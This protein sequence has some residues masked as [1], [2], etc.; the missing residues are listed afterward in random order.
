MKTWLIVLISV[1]ATFLVTFSL[2]G[3]S[4]SFLSKSAGFAMESD[5]INYRSYSPS[6]D[7][8]PE[9]EE[10]KIEKTAS[11]LTKVGRGEVDAKL[12]IA[13]STIKGMGGFVLND[14]VREHDDVRS[15]TLDIR[16]PTDNYDATIAELRKL[17]DI[18][19]FTE[20]ARDIT[21]AVVN[22]DLE[23]QVQKER[24]VRLQSLYDER[25]SLEDKIRLDELI[26]QQERTIKYLEDTL[27]KLDQKVV[28]SS[29]SLS[30][31]EPD[32]VWSALTID[33]KEI[34]K[35]CFYSLKALLYTVAAL[36]PWALVIGGVVWLI[37][38]LRRAWK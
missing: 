2:F 25:A 33:F 27:E 5:S 6:Q 35:T 24:L 37:L 14:N 34:V 23:L 12:E 21:G 30:I 16:V 10:R 29:I 9:V 11:L 3:I 4:S 36:L 26:Y 13:R 31:T 7:F 22:N 8:A 38:Y 20:N 28:Y 15:A 19:S 1:F 17:G 32:S 18:I